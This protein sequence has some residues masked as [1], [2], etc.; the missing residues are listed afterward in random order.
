VY[1][2]LETIGLY[3]FRVCMVVDV[4]ALSGLTVLCCA[5]ARQ[6]RG[7][8]KY[9]DAFFPFAILHWGQ[10]ENL[11]WNIQLVF[12]MGAC[13]NL[14]AL[15]CLVR[16]TQS[17]RSA[18]IL[19]LCTVSM[20]LIGGHGLA[21]VPAL[22]LCT[23]SAAVE[24]RKG[25]ARRALWS[26]VAAL[27]VLSLALTGFYFV[28]YVRPAK[29]P[30][31]PSLE[32]TFRSGM[33]FLSMSFGTGQRVFWPWGGYL[34]AGLL[35]TTTAALLARMTRPAERQRAFRL[36]LFF[37]AMTTLAF[38]VG[39]ARA[40]FYPHGMFVSR[41]ATLAIPLA[42]G[43]YFAWE[44]L[45]PSRLTRFMQATLFVIAT[46]LVLRN[47]DDGLMEA[48]SG[49]PLRAAFRSEV[50]RGTPIHELDKKYCRTIYYTCKGGLLGERL[51]MLRELEVPGFDKLPD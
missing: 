42:C 51:R 43:I 37:G 26:S 27:G 24:L 16:P 11:F 25:G 2:T 1:L 22:G 6:L 36:L 8:A 13:M 29:H 34:I 33:Q 23:L 20:P 31:S 48:R 39:W 46:L 12:V 49:H 40:G 28:D 14:I 4:F 47:H 18:L 21:L 30:V 7:H 45:G 41:Y 32:A 44:A 3:D 5:T 50:D 35:L 19:G 9:T 10:A 15:S 38:G 17:A